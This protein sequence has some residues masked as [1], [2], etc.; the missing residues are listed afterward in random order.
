MPDLKNLYVRLKVIADKN[1]IKICTRHSNCLTYQ[2]LK[3]ASSCEAAFVTS[4][5]V[6]KIHDGYRDEMQRQLAEIAGLNK[7]YLDLTFPKV[8]M[9]RKRLAVPDDAAKLVTQFEKLLEQHAENQKNPR[10]ALAQTLEEMLQIMRESAQRQ[11]K[12]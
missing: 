11:E 8:E 9:L 12:S 7:L 3:R 10:K 4:R 5:N 2:L 1:A 6:C